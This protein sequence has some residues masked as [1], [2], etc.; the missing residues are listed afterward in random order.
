MEKNIQ[1]KLA[2]KRGYRVVGKRCHCG[3]F[4]YQKFPFNSSYPYVFLCGV[5]LWLLLL[6]GRCRRFA[7]AGC[8]LS[9]FFTRLISI[10][11]RMHTNSLRALHCI[12]AR[13]RACSLQKSD[14]HAP[15]VPIRLQEL[16]SGLNTRA[17]TQRCSQ[18]FI[19]SMH[20]QSP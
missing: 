8:E 18:G 20:S 11:P 9:I 16:S 15:P 4:T 1:R 17:I 6:V 2:L 7:A 14:R 10:G 5:L 19:F 12:A 3:V 13:V